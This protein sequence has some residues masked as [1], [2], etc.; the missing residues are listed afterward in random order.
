MISDSTAAAVDR[1]RIEPLAEVEEAAVG[2]ARA[3]LADDGRGRRAAAALDG[4]QGEADLALGHREFD[5]RAVHLRRRHRDGHA[6]AVFEVFDQR[7]LLL[8]VAARDV[9]GEQGRHEFDRVVGLQVGGRIGDQGVGGGMALVEAVAGEL[10]D[11]AEQVGR[12]L[13]RQSALV[14][15]GDELLAVLGDGLEFLLA[16][17]LDATVGVGQGDAAEAD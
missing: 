17:R 13:L 6:L 9:A 4:R 11:E 8:E 14:G 10:L 5:V 7:V 1:A 15:A 2:S 16:D 12:F 3:A